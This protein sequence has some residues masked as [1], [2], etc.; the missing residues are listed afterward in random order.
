MSVHFIHIGVLDHF[1]HLFNFI[2]FKCFDQLFTLTTLVEIW[3]IG[4]L[5]IYFRL[6]LQY[7][8]SYGGVPFPPSTVPKP[9]CTFQQFILNM[10][11]IQ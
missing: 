10:S 11:T 6:K 9:I 2:H 1:D 3:H 8:A 7:K 4:K 5:S